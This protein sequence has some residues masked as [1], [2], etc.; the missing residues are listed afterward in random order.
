MLVVAAA[1][2]SPRRDWMGCSSSTLD[3]HSKPESC[4]WFYLAQTDLTPDETI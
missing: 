1:C 4:E 2:I 3:A